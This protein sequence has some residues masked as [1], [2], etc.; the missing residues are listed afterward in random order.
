MGRCR[1]RFVNLIIDCHLLVHT[2]GQPIFALSGAFYLPPRCSV[3]KGPTAFDIS[4]ELSPSV[5]QVEQHFT[6]FFLS[7]EHSRFPNWTRTHWTADVVR[8]DSRLFSHPEFLWLPT[9]SYYDN[10][11]Y[12]FVVN[13]NRP[14]QTPSLTAGRRLSTKSQRRPWPQARTGMA[15]ELRGGPPRAQS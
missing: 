2:C 10:P 4:V 9:P 7:G 1:R 11:S 12:F 8:H 13:S 5:N 15:W 6:N 3:T 14:A